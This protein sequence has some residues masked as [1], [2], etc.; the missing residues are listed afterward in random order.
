M[1]TLFLQ[2]REV[3]IWPAF[4]KKVTEFV[5]A[6]ENIIDNHDITQ[7]LEIERTSLNKVDIVIDRIIQWQR[8]ALHLQQQAQLLIAPIALKPPCRRIGFENSL[9]EL[10]L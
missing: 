10:T 7:R 9:S 6:N 5:S 8:I 2:R 4:G 3:E 1:K